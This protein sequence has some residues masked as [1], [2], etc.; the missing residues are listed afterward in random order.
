MVLGPDG[1]HDAGSVVLRGGVD[2]A[3]LQ[4]EQVP[5]RA[6]RGS[7]ASGTAS[8]TSWPPGGRAGRA[9]EVDTALGGVEAPGALEVDPVAAAGQ[10]NLAGGGALGDDGGGEQVRAEAVLVVA[11]NRLGVARVAQ[12]VVAQDRQAVALVHLRRRLE[13]GQQLR[14]QRRPPV[15]M[16]QDGRSKTCGRAFARI[17]TP[18]TRVFIT[19]LTA[20]SCSH[21][22]SSSSESWLSPSARKPPMSLPHI[23]IPDSPAVSPDGTCEARPSKPQPT[24]GS[25]RPHDR[26]HAAEP[27]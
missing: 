14:V 21:R 18:S 15:P 7:S 23:E 12:S 9:A 16:R 25:P 17:A 2:V 5:R 3:G 4:G 20:P 8:V 10:V 22:I 24:V 6:S 13:V 1:A 11:R 27:V 19:G 26:E